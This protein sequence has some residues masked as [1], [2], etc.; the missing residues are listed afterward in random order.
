MRPDASWGL[1]RMRRG[2]LSPMSPLP[3]LGNT[4]P[5]R[6][7]QSLLSSHSDAAFR[8]P[9]LWPEPGSGRWLPRLTLWLVGHGHLLCCSKRALVTCLPCPDRHGQQAGTGGQDTLGGWESQAGPEPE[10][11]Q[12]TKGTVGSTR[13][14]KAH[15]PPPRWAP[16]LHVRQPPQ[17]QPLSPSTCLVPPRPVR[18]L[19]LAQEVHTGSSVAPSPPC[20]PSKPVS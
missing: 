6:R 4:A 20:L 5:G 9:P 15:P 18:R 16:A 1:T 13:Y 3:G 12:A 11:L 2:H 14:Q 7:Q 17:K 8:W 10:G 19:G